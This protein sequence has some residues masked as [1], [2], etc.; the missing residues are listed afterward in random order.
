MRRSEIFDSFVKIAEEKGMISKDYH[1]GKK[2]LEQT[3]RADS[4][5]ISAIEALYGVKPDA[6]SGMEYKKNIMEDAHPN[7]VVI[8]PSYDKLNGLVE[9]NN[10]RQNILLH[11]V[12]KTPDG[13][14]TQRKYAE[15]ELLLALVRIGNDLDNRNQDELRSLSDAC[16]EQVHYK[17]FKKEAL[18]P[19]AI[20]ALVGVALGA[21][22][23]HQH[24]PNTDKGI[25][26]N[27]KSLSSEL[28][29]FLSASTGIGLVGHDYDAELKQDVRGFK[30]RLDAFMSVYNANHEAVRQLEKPRDAK[31]LVQ[32][33]Q[34]PQTQTVI[35]A[36]KNLQALIVNMATYMD[37][38]ERNFKSTAYK[39]QHTKDKGILNWL[40]ET[41]HITGGSTSLFAD[42]FQDVINAIGPFRSSVSDLLKMLE[43][44]KSLEDKAKN[45]LVASMSKSQ[46]DFGTGSGFQQ[47]PNASPPGKPEAIPVGTKGQTVEDLDKEADE[48][49]KML[50]GGASA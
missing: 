15:R 24:L 31:E 12:Q 6:P 34:Q 2:V 19:L 4:L 40:T 28:N 44:A 49:S 14:L 39:A 10:E 29:D 20:I 16:L 23:A 45:D 25:Q 9:N 13:L 22:Y 42:D 8:S 47:I 33:A 27:Y 7:S 48:L 17:G 32:I 26:E 18:G 35:T 3:G 1:A 43:D 5:D 37:Q 30:E 11:I 21:I 38:V 41:T 46:S 36:Y 50:G